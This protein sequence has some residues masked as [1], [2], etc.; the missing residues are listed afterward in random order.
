[1]VRNK[2]N[3]RLFA[4]AVFCCLAVAVSGFSFFTGVSAQQS[5]QTQRSRT[6]TAAT[7][8]PKPK[9]TPKPSPAPTL[10]PTPA[11]T[12]VPVQTLIELQT[13]IRSILLRPQFI[14]SQIGIK[15]VSLDTGKVMFEQ[16]AEKYFMPASNMKTFT[17]STAL[18]K[19]TPD[20]RFVT[21][22]YAGAK[23]DAGG[24]IKGD[25]TVYGRGDPSIAAA[26]NNGDYYKG[27]E[28]LAD[29]IVQAGV[30]RVEGSLVGDESYFTGEPIPIGWEWD[31]L[32][33]YYGAEI[34]ALTVNDNS[35]DVTVR[36]GSSVG[37]F[38]SVT[39][40]PALPGI[41]LKNRVTTAPAGAKRESEIFKP[42]GQNVFDVSGRIA[43]NDPGAVANF[44]SVAINRPALA[45]MTMLR[46]LLEQKGVV[47]TGQTR[48]VNAKEKA[49]LSVASSTPWIEIAKLE[50]PPLSVIAAKTLKPSQNLYTELILRAL[51]ETLGDKTVPNKTSDQR[52]IAV[53]D[54]FLQEMGVA[55]GSV[56]M[57]DGSGLSR[58]D[59]VTP[60]ALVQAFTFMSR[61]SYAAVW[62][63]ALPIGGVD[64]TL[65][66]R[67]KGAATINNVRAKTGTIDQVSS[68]SGYMTT[69]SGERLAF[70]IMTNTVPSQT[71]RQNTI[72]EIVLL[73]AGYNGKSN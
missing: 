3:K 21:S 20:F 22:V 63:D 43:I 48:V 27:M 37:A 11:A 38:A 6:T 56:L 71:L 30:K 5:P 45:F 18:A 42:L 73:L 23:P 64:G 69:A 54:K 49:P 7:P 46:Q 67:L 16:N 35:L 55:D 32:Q 50:S 4:V 53:V 15:V 24:V 61:H 9:T 29:R 39:L 28:N 31:D 1:M 65:K 57:A 72:D 66:N 34:S 41:T 25:L 47:I 2:I 19:L 12:P 44:G 10:S 14:R 60:A 59:L 70:S 36:P 58:H 8:T 52:G 33:W 13:S 51:G 62:R 17:V 68:L 26:F 40:A